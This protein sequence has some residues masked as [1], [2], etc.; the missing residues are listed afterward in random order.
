[1]ANTSRINGFRVVKKIGG[2]NDSMVN[3][4]YVPNAADE[5]LV[6]DIV[7]LSGTADV[8][9][10]A[11]VDLA[12]AGDVPVGVI[13]AV[14]HS[15]FDPV[16]KMTTGSTAL[17]VPAVTQIAAAGAGYVLVN[18][19]PDVLLEGE[20]SNGT[21]AAVDI[22]QNVSHANAARTAST[23]TSPATIDM[24]TKNTTSTLNFQL[25]GFVQRVGNEIGASAKM[26]VRFNVHQFNSVGTTGV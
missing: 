2:E 24:G 23:T 20:T 7:K 19:S 22:G 14:L 11:T 6:G 17:D 9:G 16:G 3:V 1:M 13:V 8:N 4:Y 25:V 21:P 5:M 26:L 15:K 18:D 10:I 12:A